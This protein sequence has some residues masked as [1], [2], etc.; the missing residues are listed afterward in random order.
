MAADATQ[1]VSSWLE[2]LGWIDWTAVG[3]LAVSALFGLV[4]GMVW[5][6]GRVVTLL[7]AY[8]I[9]AAFGERSGRL[10]SGWLPADSPPDFGTYAA[11]ALIFVCVLVVVGVL[12]GAIHRALQGSPLSIVNR[13]GG[14]VFGVAT[15][16]LLVLALLTGIQ[17]AHGSLGFGA[18]VAQ[19]ASTSNSTRLGD[20][21]IA[22]S[23]EVL[24][25]SWRSVANDWR[26]LLAG[27]DGG[28][29]EPGGETPDEAGS[30]GA[31]RP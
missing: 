20:R 21:A 29:A 10:L 4:R 17:M 2:S 16:G 15:G 19:A 3:I 30:A 25:M 13:L 9:A 26:G 27:A 8:A 23:S 5:Q 14:A 28:R 12:F 18:S 24:P 6:V 7:A 11:F 31:R 1:Q 22:A